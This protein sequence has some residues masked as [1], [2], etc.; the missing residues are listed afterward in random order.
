MSPLRRVTHPVAGTIALDV[1]GQGPC[2]LLVHGAGGARHS[3]DAITPHLAPHLKL[4]QVDL[5]GHGDSTCADDFTP[6]LDAVAAVLAE[7]LDEEGLSPR[8]LIGHSAGAAVSALIADLIVDSASPTV[9]VAIAPAVVPLSPLRGRAL[10]A[11]AAIGAALPPVARVIAARADVAGSI[12][13][14]VKST[15]S[16][17]SPEGI[18]RYR[19]VSRRVEHVRGVLRFL[20][21]S[22]HTSVWRAWPGLVGR[23]VAVLCIAG[24]GDLAIPLDEQRKAADVAGCRLS[25]LSDCGHLVHEERPAD[26][27]ALILAFARAHELIPSAQACA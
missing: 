9:L 4:V 10:R 3:F 6:S 13:R 19:A 21:A 25:I 15:G 23:G 18:A 27:A 2:A 1:V 26:V 7:I 16:R 14:L 20:A 24:E 22:D 12:E 17:L 8:V 11:L 5:P